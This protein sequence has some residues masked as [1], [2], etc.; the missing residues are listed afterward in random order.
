[1]LN[2]TLCYLERG[3]RYL[4]LHRVKKA[5]DLN[6]G[7]WVGVGGKCEEGESPEECLLREVRE[8]TGLLLTQYRYRGLVTFVSDRWPGEYM[9]LFTASGWS[10]P[11]GPQSAPAARP[12]PNGQAPVS[13]A[14]PAAPLPECREG[15]LEWIP[16][17]DLPSLPMWEGDAIFLRL[18]EE[19]APFFSLKLQYQGERLIY[20]ALD[21]RGIHRSIHDP[22]ARWETDPDDRAM[23]MET[24]SSN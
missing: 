6:E 10:W 14:R 18:L 11:D 4:M 23:G 13:D 2:T 9:H 17:R 1:M 15:V 3:D 22:D 8:E 20:A 12:A 21:G 16:K 19:N 5:N 7:K 24:R